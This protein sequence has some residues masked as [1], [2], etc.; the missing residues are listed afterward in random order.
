VGGSHD[1]PNRRRALGERGRGPPGDLAGDDHNIWSQGAARV[2]AGGP[3]R[4]SPEFGVKSPHPSLW[5]VSCVRSLPSPAR[6]RGD[7]ARPWARYASGPSLRALHTSRRARQ[8]PF[9]PRER[10]HCSTMGAL[11]VRREQQRRTY[12]QSC[13][14]WKATPKTSVN[15]SIVPS[16]G[17]MAQA[18]APGGAA[19]RSSAAS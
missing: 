4:P 8:A 14:N 11:R 2:E 16:G 12:E 10:G 6:G 7:N 17:P 19:E 1:S 3:R 15:R 5:R 13:P 9:S 18:S